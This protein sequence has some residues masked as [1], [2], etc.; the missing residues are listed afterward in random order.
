L[1]RLGDPA[2]GED[3]CAV[4]REKYCGKHPRWHYNKM[5]SVKTLKRAW[6]DIS[7]EVKAYPK[8]FLPLDGSEPV[9]IGGEKYLPPLPQRSK[10]R[11]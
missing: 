4:L 3:V 5:K 1:K 2:R 8:Q 10:A 11:V 9:L 6:E 7:A